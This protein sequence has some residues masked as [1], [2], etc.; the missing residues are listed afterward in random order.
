MCRLDRANEAITMVGEVHFH[1]SKMSISLALIFIGG[2]HTYQGYVLDIEKMRN[3]G[4][5]LIFGGVVIW[6]LLWA[7]YEDQKRGRRWW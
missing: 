6:G 5:I 7:Y 4:L 3:F 2:V 1:I